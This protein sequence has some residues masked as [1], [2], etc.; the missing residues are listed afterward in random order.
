MGKT[1]GACFQTPGP[2]YCIVGDGP[3]GE[4]DGPGFQ[5]RKLVGQEA[6]TGADFRCNRLVLWRKTFDRVGDPAIDELQTIVNGFRVRR[7]TKPVFIERLV[8]QKTG[9][10][11]GK[12]PA[13][14]VGT[15]FA[16]CQPDNQKSGIRITKWWY[17]SAVIVRQLSFYFIKKC[18]KAL[19]APAVHIKLDSYRVFIRHVGIVEVL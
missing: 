19:A 10:I 1:I 7:C 17:G 6:D 3:Q 18:C 2:E 8:Q 9:V 12:R 14:S 13:G 16:R 11:S 5:F 15:V 4:N